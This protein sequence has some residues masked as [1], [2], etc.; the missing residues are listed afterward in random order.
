M[1]FRKCCKWNLRYYYHLD[2]NRGTND[3]KHDNCG[4]NDDK[5]DNCGT[6]D[7]DDDRVAYYHKHKHH[8][9][10]FKHNKFN[11]PYG[12]NNINDF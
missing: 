2:D 6:N 3:D 10:D 12:Y 7:H 4:T 11:N 1:A 5:H 9:V 8:V